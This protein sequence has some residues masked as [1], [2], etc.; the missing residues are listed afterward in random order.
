[1]RDGGVG[2]HVGNN[3]R[4][5]VLGPVL[6]CRDGAERPVGPPQRQSVFAMPLLAEGRPISAAKLVDGLWGA[7][8]PGRANGALRSVGGGYAL[9][10][11]Y[12]LV[13]AG[14]FEQTVARAE[15]R[16]QAGAITE[17]SA[18]SR[19]AP[20]L[21]RGEPLAGLPGP[22]A[23]R[24]RARLA[25]RRPAVLEDRLELDL[26]AGR[27]AKVAAL[28]THVANQV[29]G[30]FPDGQLY[31]ELHGVDRLPASPERVLSSFLVGLGVAEQVVPD[32]VDERSALLRSMLAG[33]RVLLDDTRDARQVKAH[34]LTA[35]AAA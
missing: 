16:R 8:P 3:L 27:D 17:A 21:H 35:G 18:L 24:H 31:A 30:R 19:E 33:R 1:V 4:F 32:G 34:A 14:F 15:R 9:D 5:G 20:S 13:D 25:E 7:H 11:D 2:G 12:A 29:A 28:P 6:A 23:V 26:A 10:V 22:Y